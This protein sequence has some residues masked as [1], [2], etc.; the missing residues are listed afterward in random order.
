[1]LLSSGLRPAI[2]ASESEY[3]WFSAGAMILI[4]AFG[5]FITWR[6]TGGR[7]GI[8][9]S[10]LMSLGALVATAA[11]AL[12]ILETWDTTNVWGIGF[13]LSVWLFVLAG[14]YKTLRD[15]KRKRDS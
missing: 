7:G 15:E 6:F 4:A 12:I 9:A 1:M 11:I 13:L 10:W 8:N 5:L 3:G 14:F 2:Q